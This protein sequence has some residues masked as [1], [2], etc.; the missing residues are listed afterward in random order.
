MTTAAILN[1]NL[2]VKPN[3]LKKPDPVSLRTLMWE[4]WHSFPNWALAAGLFFEI[5][6]FQWLEAGMIAASL[7]GIMCVGVYPEWKAQRDLDALFKEADAFVKTLRNGKY[8]VIISIL[9]VRIFIIVLI[10][11]IRKS[12]LKI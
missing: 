12:M 6:T 10:I 1:L 8:E 5:I 7:S 3:A 2:G 4:A 11:V 9:N